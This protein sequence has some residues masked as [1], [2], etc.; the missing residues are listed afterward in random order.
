MPF[1]YYA[2]V[3]TQLFTEVN[4][5]ILRG[6]LSFS[7]ALGGMWSSL[8]GEGGQGYLSLGL[9]IPVILFSA[10]AGQVSDRFGKHGVIR[11]AKIAELPVALAAAIA[12]LMGSPWLAL[13]CMLLLTIHTTF[14][15]PARLSAL[16]ELV[17]ERAL[18]RANGIMNFVSSVGT[19]GATALAGPLYLACDPSAAPDALT[20]GLVA[21]KP[22]IVG[23]VLLTIAVLGNL[24]VLFVPKLPAR[25]PNVRLSVNPIPSYGRAV[26]EMQRSALWL[27]ALAWTLTFVLGVNVLLILPDYRELLSVSPTAAAA[28]LGLL[29]ITVGV[30]SMIA[31]LICR[32]KIELRLIPAAALGMLVAF[33]ALGTA[34]LV[35]TTVSL[36]VAA[37]GLCAG[38]YMTPLQA[39]L[40][41]LSPDSD[42]G[43]FLG[44]ANALS[45]VGVLFGSIV[46]LCAR[47]VMAANHVFLVLAVLLLI[48]VGILWLRF[49]AALDRSGG[50]HWSSLAQSSVGSA[51]SSRVGIKASSDIR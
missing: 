25:S 15:D 7:L 11:V 41:K 48:C 33:I 8:F 18:G 21:P 42:R 29:G 19:I 46:F 31:G 35:Y 22:W 12:F 43:R 38:L 10:I 26:R 9:T 24:T 16:P 39:L 50:A 6:V 40:Q 20:A 36:L 17:S 51:D 23:V 14:F 27:V 13:L 32:R 4:D 1:G 30:G 47:Q 37:A 34:P 44:T 49:R 45:F 2:L 5:N 28:L 3:A